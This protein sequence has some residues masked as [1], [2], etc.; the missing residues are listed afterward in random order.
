M[1]KAQE[2]QLFDH[3]CRHRPLSEWLTDQLS[4]QVSVLLVNSDPMTLAKA[5]GAAAF[6]K[7]FQDKIIAAEN[8][9]R[10]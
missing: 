9:A 3:L 5:Q 10:R 7:V 6:I 2:S 4:K 1:D 8:S